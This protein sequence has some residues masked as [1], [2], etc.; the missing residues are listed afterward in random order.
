MKVMSNILNEK[1][2]DLLRYLYRQTGP[3]PSD[4]LD[5]RVVRAL[6]ARD[7]IT[8]SK[9]WVAITDAG[10]ERFD[11]AVRRRRAPAASTPE[12]G[13]RNARAE[14][15]MRAIDALELALPKDAEVVVGEM[16]AYADDVVEGF[17]R[18]A[19]TLESSRRPVRVRV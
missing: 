1:Q 9:G 8:E 4:H 19:R 16:F 7:L 5:G 15:I 12:A 3:V 11:H 10:R 17:R 18:Y 6:R 13:G 2:F 14:S